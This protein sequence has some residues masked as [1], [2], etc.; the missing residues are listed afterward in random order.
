MNWEAISA[1]GEITDALAVVLTLG[2]FGIQA[3]AA[4]EAAADTNRL[5]LSNGVREIMLAS[6][7]NTEIRQALEKGLGT[8]PYMT[9]FLK[10][11]VFLKM[12]LSSCTGQC[13]HGSGYTGGSMH[14]L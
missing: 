13:L 10:S 7:A 11:L 12:K 14:L 3:R 5:H 2:Y 6:T 9:C 8:S 4:T 1:I